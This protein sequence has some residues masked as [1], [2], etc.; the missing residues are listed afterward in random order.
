[1]GDIAVT[2]WAQRG[3]IAVTPVDGLIHKSMLSSAVAIPRSDDADAVEIRA[4]VAAG[5]PVAALINLAL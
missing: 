4:P 2:P 3:D 5:A 1:M